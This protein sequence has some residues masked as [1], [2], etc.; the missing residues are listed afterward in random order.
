MQC[1]YVLV[2]SDCLDVRAVRP[3]SLP[4]SGNFLSPHR[5]SRPIEPGKVRGGDAVLPEPIMPKLGPPCFAKSALHG[6]TAGV[7]H[8]RNIKATFGLTRLEVCLVREDLLGIVPR[9]NLGLCHWQMHST[10]T[11]FQLHISLALIAALQYIPGCQPEK[12]N[13]TQYSF[14]NVPFGH[15]GDSADAIQLWRLNWHNVQ[16]GTALVETTWVLDG[17]AVAIGL[18]GWGVQGCRPAGWPSNGGSHV[19][20]DSCL[21]SLLISVSMFAN[22]SDIVCSN[23]QWFSLVVCLS[24]CTACWVSVRCSCRAGLF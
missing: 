5:D 3:G 9:V 21:V 24:S 8:E 13:C 1:A 18:Q 22:C 15:P 10:R 20:F 6:T 16:P 4:E 2:G 23:L 19:L 12:S 11:V 17:R 7:A 14:R